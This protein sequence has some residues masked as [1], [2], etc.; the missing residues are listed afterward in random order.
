MNLYER[1]TK[2]VADLIKIKSITFDEG[3][4]AKYIAEFLKKLGFK[5]EVD[6]SNNV[7]GKFEGKGDGPTLFFLGHHDT[8]EEGDHS[9][10]EYPPFLGEVIDGKLWG[11]GAVDEK[12]GIGA[13]LAAVEKIVKE[14]KDS[15]RGNILVVSTR[16]E[17]S[18]ITTRGIMEVLRKGIVAD[19]CVVV[20]P[21]E[22]DIVLGHKGRLVV[23]I[24][25]FGKS[26][27]SSVPQKGINAVNHMAHILVELEKMELPYRLPLGQ[28]TQSV[29]VIKGGVRPNIV[30][31]KCVIEIDRRIVGEETPDSVREEI[32]NVLNSL[33]EK[34]PQLEV[35]IKMKD[36]FYPSYI[37]EESPIVS[38]T[39]KSCHSLGMKPRIYYEDFHT[40]GEWIVNNAKIPA[41][42]LGPG[43]IKL[44]HAV[45]E[46]V[47]VEELGK[48]AEIYYKI[49]ENSIV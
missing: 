12:G 24:T 45:N 41:I 38:I 11:R 10:W 39:E 7:I 15:L 29:G 33:K 26:A 44:A 49:M 19:Y 21:T 46:R 42:V 17:T 4:A 43:S 40:D 3:N 37:T 6:K 30:P 8:V 22:L 20:E 9:L 18:D 23:E 36:P 25:T 34:I 16:E 31:E 5:V 1:S 27:H 32:T 2:I 28:G 13:C 14:N 35:K 48:A 47:S